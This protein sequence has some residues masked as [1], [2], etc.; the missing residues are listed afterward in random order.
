MKRT[1]IKKG[2]LEYTETGMQSIKPKGKKKK[3]ANPEQ[4]VN[5]E[6]PEEETDQ[7]IDLEEKTDQETDLEEETDQEQE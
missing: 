5:P 1:L 2:V 4:K 6:L 3:K 7:E